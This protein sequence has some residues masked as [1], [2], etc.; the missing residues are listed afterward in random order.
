MIGV[1]QRVSE[2]EVWVQG[3]RIARIG[4]GVL[5]LVGIDR[6]DG[7]GDAEYLARKSAELRIFADERGNLNRSLRET[8]G[9]VLVVSQFTLLGDTRKGRRP[10]FSRAASPEQ[11]GQ[12]YRA[13]VDELKRRGL[14]VEEGRFRAMMEVRLT[15]SGPVTVMVD[16]AHRSRDAAL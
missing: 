8:G 2:A 12:L 3:V 9:S 11:A 4:R 15:N 10:S 16:S 1:L 6:E 7:P 5:L 13:L 14:T